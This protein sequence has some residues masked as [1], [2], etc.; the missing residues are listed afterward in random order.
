MRADTCG[1]EDARPVG[2]REIQRFPHRDDMRRLRDSFGE[3]VHSAKFR[4]VASIADID[5]H[6]EFVESRSAEFTFGSLGSFDLI[7]IVGEGRPERH[8]EA[9]GE[10][11]EASHCHTEDQKDDRRTPVS[12][13]NFI[14]RSCGAGADDVGA[15][16]FS[17]PSRISEV[18]DCPAAPFGEAGQ[19]WVRPDH[20]FSKSPA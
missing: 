8:I 14:D 1:V 6:D 16:C 12:V 2:E 20:R 5:H 13:Q 10:D 9:H 18:A 4:G 19:S 17:L 3:F 11:T 15:H 7:G